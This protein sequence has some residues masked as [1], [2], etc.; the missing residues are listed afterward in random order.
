M[1]QIKII[2][3]APPS[4]VDARLV[5]KHSD[6]VVFATG[7][8]KRGLDAAIV[9]AD[10]AFGFPG[11][12]GGDVHIVLPVQE[13]MNGWALK[14]LRSSRPQKVVWDCG[15]RQLAIAGEVLRRGGVD[16]VHFCTTKA[17]ELCGKSGAAAAR[18]IAKMASPAT[19]ILVTADD[20]AWAARNGGAVVEVSARRAEPGL[21]DDGTGRGAAWLTGYVAALEEGA[22]LAEAMDIA[23]L[24][25]AAYIASG[26]DV[27]AL[28]A[29]GELAAWRAA[30]PLAHPQASLPRWLAKAAGFVSS[31][32]A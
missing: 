2:S 26:Q 20:A 25:A 10:L 8:Q 30:L 12:I 3:G 19:R 13:S 31:W 4:P 14:Y 9:P 29:R 1:K 5:S 22:S 16:E 18:A 21:D 27:D 7:L 6:D 32:M 28:P 23:H 15:S 17:R 24:T 11:A